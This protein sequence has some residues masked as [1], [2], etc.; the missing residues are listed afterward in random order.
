MRRAEL[1]KAQTAEAPAQQ[2]AT[3]EQALRDAEQALHVAEAASEQLCLIGSGWKAP[4]RQ[5]APPVE[6]RIGLRPRRPEQ[7]RTPCRHTE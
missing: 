5:P 1:K 7:T 3:L 6:N 4:D 2:I